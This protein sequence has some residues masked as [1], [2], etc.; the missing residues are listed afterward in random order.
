MESFGISLIE[1]MASGIPVETT[2][3]NGFSETVI[4]GETGYLVKEHDVDGMAA[5]ILALLEDP[6][7]AMRMGRAGRAWVENTFTDELAAARL[8]YIMALS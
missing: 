3:H 4:H 5:I 2:E 7:Q 6:D 1:A 8:R